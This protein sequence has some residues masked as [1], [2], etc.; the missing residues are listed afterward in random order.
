MPDQDS[1]HQFVYRGSVPGDRPGEYLHF[2]AAGGHALGDLD[3][4]DVEAPRVA[5]ARLLER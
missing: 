3:H 2:H 4:V 1:G 5:G